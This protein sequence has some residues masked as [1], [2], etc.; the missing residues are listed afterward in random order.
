MPPF[1]YNWQVLTLNIATVSPSSLT[2]TVLNYANPQT[3]T[4][5]GVDDL[6][7]NDGRTTTIRHT[8]S[9]GGYTG[10]NT[11]QFVVSLTDDDTDTAPSFA[12]ASIPNQSYTL[13]TA[14]TSLQ[15]P[16]ALSGNGATTYTLSPST[17]PAGLSHNM[18][19][20]TIEGTPT[21]VSA[22]TTYTYTAMDQD[23]DVVSLTFTIT[24]EGAA[25]VIASTNE[26]SINEMGVGNTATYT[27]RLNSTPTGNVVVTP[28]SSAPGSC[29]GI[30]LQ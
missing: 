15:L 6:L 27:I 9:G 8:F 14:I 21:A 4:V 26:V 16:T 24:V 19:N 30:L 23:D 13:G 25:S 11:N 18:T 12:A 3:V 5:R 28:V 29:H 7:D 20:R 10:Y 22:T 17:L 1:L 2:F